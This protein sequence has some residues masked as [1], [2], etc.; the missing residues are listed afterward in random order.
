MY[1]LPCKGLI[2]IETFMKK[3]IGKIVLLPHACPHKMCRNAY[4]MGFALS[5][6]LWLAMFNQQN[7]IHVIP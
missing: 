6:S 3:E 2:Y 5:H 4:M 7:V 1:I